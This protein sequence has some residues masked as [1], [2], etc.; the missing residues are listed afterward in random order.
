MYSKS[1]WWEHP[2]CK[3]HYGKSSIGFRIQQ[4][5]LFGI[6]T[7]AFLMSLISFL[8]SKFSLNTKR[9]VIVTFHHP[10][11]L[12]ALLIGL[13]SGLLSQHWQT[14]WGWKRLLRGFYITFSLESNPQLPQLMYQMP[15]IG[16]PSRP[17]VVVLVCDSGVKSL[18]HLI[19][20]TRT[21]VGHELL[22]MR[23]T[24]SFVAIATPPQIGIMVQHQKS[25]SKLLGISFLLVK[26]F[27]CGGSTSQ[28]CSCKL[29]FQ[30]IYHLLTT[31]LSQ[32]FGRMILLILNQLLL[33]C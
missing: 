23:Y 19:K 22:E 4:D 15:C 12:L 28:V 7:V 1:P 24:M 17:L 2:Q 21:P 10:F 31:E 14:L 6:V 8:T 20:L 18:L 29:C 5:K 27:P 9:L 26:G 25:Q 33:P 13:C 30:C 32:A 16:I 3:I 11:N